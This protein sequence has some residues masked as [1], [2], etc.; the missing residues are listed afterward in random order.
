M[1]RHKKFS[2]V[3]NPVDPKKPYITKVRKIKKI[4]FHCTATPAS[5]DTRAKDVDSMHIKRWGINSGCGYHFLITRE[6]K[7]EKGR[8]SDS[9]GSHAGP[10]KKLG[11]I[12]SNP[13]TLGVVYSGGVD[14]DLKIL[15]EGMNDKQKET[16]AILLA[17][18]TDGYELDE[19]DIIG[20]NEI[21]LVNKGCP[22]TS[23][24]E[25]RRKVRNA[26]NKVY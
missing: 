2:S 3:G 25:L 7:I 12:S 18:L 4:V 24:T 1:K 11:R 5:H 6:G 9:N 22:C 17:A 16:A 19:T 21:P 15:D 13:E 10:N 20:H 23:M 14:D 8:W 26:Y